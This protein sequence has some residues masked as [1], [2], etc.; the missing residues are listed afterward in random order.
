MSG[1]TSIVYLVQSW[2]GVAWYRAH[3]PGTALKELGYEVEATDKI[4]R[5]WIEQCDVMVVSP[6][7]DPRVLQAVQYVKQRGGLAVLDIDDDYW[8][9]HPD[10]PSRWSN[11]Q[12]D[13]LVSIARTVDLVTTTTEELLEIMRPMNPSTR[14]LRNVLPDE[15]WPQSLELPRRAD[16]SLVLGW[17]GGNAHGPDIRMVRQVM[18]QLLDEFP[19]LEVHLAVVAEQD[20]PNHP[21]VKH[22]QPVPINKYSGLLAG[23]DIAVAPLVDTRFNRCKSDLKFLEYAMMGLP[24]VASRVAPYARSIDHGVNGY[25]AK[26]AKDWLKYLRLLITDQ[27]ARIRVG[28]A[29]RAFAEKRRISDNIG[30]WVKAYGLGDTHS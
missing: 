24:V 11:P 6:S 23:F 16:S 27:E 17:A 30:R 22:L 8:T 19:Q 18:E 7:G 21:R 29:A 28:S 25:L 1:R 26:N 9:L 2:W 15:H 10:N 13:N 14:I 12:L 5:R 3:V 4:D 20:A